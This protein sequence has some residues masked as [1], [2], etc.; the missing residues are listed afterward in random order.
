MR[1]GFQ[2]IRVTVCYFYFHFIFVYHIFVLGYMTHILS[3]SHFTYLV[4]ILSAIND[5]IATTSDSG[6]KPTFIIITS[7]VPRAGTLFTGA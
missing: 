1:L 3:Y 6:N 5:F 4:V 2:G 7:N